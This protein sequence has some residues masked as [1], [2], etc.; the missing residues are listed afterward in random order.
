MHFVNYGD[1]MGVDG[2]PRSRP[3]LKDDFFWPFAQKTLSDLVVSTVQ[4][5][6]CFSDLDPPDKI[7]PHQFLKLVAS[8]RFK[9]YS[10]SPLGESWLSKMMGSRS[11]SIIKKN[12]VDPLI[13]D[14]KFRVMVP[15]G[16]IN[17]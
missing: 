1:K 9:H 5:A 17:E 2:I 12:Y 8:Y 4:K 10:H 3:G 16:T 7:G 11:T 15:L 14:V 13:P 6:Y